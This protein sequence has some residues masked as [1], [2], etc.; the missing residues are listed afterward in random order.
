[1]S[2]GWGNIRNEKQTRMTNGVLREEERED[3][4]FRKFL[5]LWPHIGV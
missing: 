5:S 4:I 1:M 2:G 3:E